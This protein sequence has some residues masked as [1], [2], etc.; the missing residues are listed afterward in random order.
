MQR[1][2]E[3]EE[4]FV[5]LTRAAVKFERLRAKESNGLVN[6]S[7]RL[8]KQRTRRLRCMLRA[9][10]MIM[11]HG[12][13]YRCGR[14]QFKSDGAECRGLFVVLARSNYFL[15]TDATDPRPDYNFLTAASLP[16][17]VKFESLNSGQTD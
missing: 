10:F 12:R 11:F 3:S 2:V 17:V 4:Q 15:S 6:F 9:R 14:Y 1:R 16:R 5:R 13:V 8:R 7:R